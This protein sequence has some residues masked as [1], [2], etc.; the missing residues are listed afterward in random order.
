[1]TDDHSAAR[2]VIARCVYDQEHIGSVDLDWDV[3]TESF[4]L[5]YR[6]YA[7]DP[8]IAA[9]NAAGYEITRR[10]PAAGR[11][12][13]PDTFST[14]TI[15]TKDVGGKPVLYS[16]IIDGQE[17]KFAGYRIALDKATGTNTEATT[18]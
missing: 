17:I 14:Y 6:E 10:V 1:M 13:I 11:V 15:T 7:A 16:L 18:G 9:L 3:V 8:I 4:R 5:A 12:T 2:D